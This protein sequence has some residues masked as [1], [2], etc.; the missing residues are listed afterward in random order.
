MSI[1]TDIE[2]DVPRRRRGRGWVGWSLLAIV[3]TGAVVVA[4]LPAPY[5]IEQP[6]PVFDTLGDVYVGGEEVPMIN[7]PMEETF[8]TTGALNMLTVNL[9]GQPEDLP[10]WVEVALA[11]IDQTRAVVPVEEI[12]PPGVTAQDSAQQSR[13]DMENSQKEAIAAALTYLGNEFGSTLTVA[14]TIADTPA[15]GVLLAGD[16]IVSVN[17]EPAVDVTGLRASI[18]TNGVSKPAD[19]L[20]V[21]D[22]VEM[23]K[24][25]NPELSEG[26]EPVAVIGVIIESAYD[27]PFTVEIQLDNVGGPS[28]GMMFA[29]GIVDKL[30]PGS[31]N[32]G[33]NVA[34]TGT[35]SSTG[36]VGPIG[37]IRQKLWGAKDA[38]AAWF[39]APTLNCD[40]VSGHIP[41]G[42]T[43]FAVDTLTESMTALAAIRSDGDTSGI[44][45]CPVE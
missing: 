19:V 34:G 23:T 20:I 17:G 9:R 22:G 18:A 3:V 10:N 16:V 27:F 32:G 37:G 1:F 36:E 25:I 44:P 15:D 13:V 6:G 29:L 40:E 43:V 30:T 21:R 28:A 45:R 14:E 5:V 39:L 24:R 7:I 12:F 11:Q 35:I 8:P 33:E 4:L 38:G 26:S 31:L 2:P 41:P 42:L